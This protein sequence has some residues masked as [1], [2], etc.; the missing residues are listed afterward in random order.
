[1]K[2]EKRFKNEYRRATGKTEKD[3]A[4]KVFNNDRE[5]CDVC[6]M[7]IFNF[8]AICRRCGFTVCMACFNDRLNKVQYEDTGPYFDEYE[9]Y[10]YTDL[11][12]ANHHPAAMDL[13]YFHEELH[14]SKINETMKK[15]GRRFSKCSAETM[16]GGKNDRCLPNMRHFYINNGGLLVL[17]EPYNEGSIAH[18]RKHWRNAHRGE[19][20]FYRCYKS[21]FVPFHILY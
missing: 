9:W 13:C 14:P 19:S 3:I 18:F 10:F 5:V 17:E 21:T 2:A 7:S 11:S 4:L 6:L 16:R 20:A 12:M 15:L 1:L 8:H